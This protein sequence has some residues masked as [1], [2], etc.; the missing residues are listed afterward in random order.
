MHRSHTSGTGRLKEQQSR[1]RQPRGCAWQEGTTMQGWEEREEVSSSGSRCGRRGL[2]KP[3]GGVSVQLALQPLRTGY[4]A[5]AL[6]SISFF[7]FLIE[8]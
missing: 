7:F 2:S 5:Q 8:G 3:L 4:Q 1:L 6:E